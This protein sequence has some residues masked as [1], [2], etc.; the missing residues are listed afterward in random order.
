MI[1]A[2]AFQASVILRVLAIAI[3]VAGVADP[4]V[5]WTATT[6]ARLAIVELEP[7]T[8]ASAQVRTQLARDLGHAYEILPEVTS[9]AHA[10]FVIG[11][12][13]PDRPLASAFLTDAASRESA[14]R[15]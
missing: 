6:P 4:A 5:T 3:A 13:Y 8:D 14:S 7:T 11:D 10:A 12:R 1:G 2:R 15:T 9:D